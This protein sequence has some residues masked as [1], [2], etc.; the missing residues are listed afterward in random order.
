M[1]GRR[2]HCKQL[3]RGM[4]VQCQLELS[5]SDKEQL[6]CLEELLA[7]L[8]VTTSNESNDQQQGFSMFDFIILHKVF[9][10]ICDNIKPV[11]SL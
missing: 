5:C 1:I 9:S 2:Q 3:C 11:Y 8:G 6:Q 7:P 10:S 4:E